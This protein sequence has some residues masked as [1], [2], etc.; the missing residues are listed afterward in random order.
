MQANNF[1][2]VAI[3]LLPYAIRIKV[4]QGVNPDSSKIPSVREESLR[5]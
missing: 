4:C 1:V 3:E 5:S 2:N